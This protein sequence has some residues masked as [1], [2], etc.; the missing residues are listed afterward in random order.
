MAV[1][2]ESNIVLVKSTPQVIFEA[3]GGQ[4]PGFFSGS[5]D[6]TQLPDVDDEVNI[7]LEIKYSSGGTYRE[8]HIPSNGKQADKAVEFTPLEKTY[9]YKLTAELVAAS[10]SAS[11]T[12]EFLMLRSDA[13]T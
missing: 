5:L 7:K 2:V 10:P 11:A 12:L 1:V 4:L 3:S 6:L 9:G 8:H 13:P